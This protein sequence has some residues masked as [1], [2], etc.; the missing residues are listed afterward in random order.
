MTSS[1]THLSPDLLRNI[2][3]K[4][5]RLFLPKP[6]IRKR[7]QFLVHSYNLFEESMT[8]SF[9]ICGMELIEDHTWLVEFER[10]G[11]P[12]F[13]HPSFFLAKQK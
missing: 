2:F 9:P 5:E 6:T 11:S 12:A 7:G 8:L 10:G 13:E 1:E 3:V 4:F